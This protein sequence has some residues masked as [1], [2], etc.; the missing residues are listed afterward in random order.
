MTTSKTGGG[1]RVAAVIHQLEQRADDLSGRAAGAQKVL[2]AWETRA[3]RF[4]RNNPGSVLVGA[5]AL[6][7]I[8][9]RVARDA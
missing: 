7:F 2:A 6:G 1:G 8:V 5:V 9:A 3:R 4:V